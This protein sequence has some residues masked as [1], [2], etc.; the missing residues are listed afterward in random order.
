LIKLLAINATMFVL[1]LGIGLYAQST[2]LIADAIDML[3]DSIVYAIGLYAVGRSITQK[4]SA[5]LLSGWFQLGLGLL[6][7]LDIFRRIFVGSEPVSVLMMSVGTVAL[8]ANIVCLKLIEEHRHG[9]VHMRASWIFSKNDVIANAGVILGG[10]LVW[11][12]DS[13][14]PDLIIG[15]LIALLVLKGAKHIIQ[16]ARKE[17]A[18]ESSCCESGDC[19]PT[20]NVSIGTIE[21]PE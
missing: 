6:I 10:L 1:E 9:E 8:I 5:A 16:D 7:I 12:L 20:A 21:K 3:A 15:S 17:I 19:C 11:L 2:G 4:A 18:S 14:W 13:R